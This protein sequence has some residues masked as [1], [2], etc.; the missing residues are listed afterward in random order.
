LSSLLGTGSGVGI[1]PTKKAGSM[2]AAEISA[3][4]LPGLQEEDIQISIPVGH[5]SDGENEVDQPHFGSVALDLQRRRKAAVFDVFAP[6][7]TST[8]LRNGRSAPPTLPISAASRFTT[9]Q[10]TRHPLSLS[11]LHNAVQGAVASKRYACSHLLALRF[12]E[13]DADEAYWENVRSVMGLLTSTFVDAS[14]RLTEALDDLDKTK[15]QDQIPTPLPRS[16]PSSD[17]GE[18]H[19]LHERLLSFAPMPSHLAR[20]AAHVDVISTALSDARDHLEECVAS[21]RNNSPHPEGLY[22]SGSLYPSTPASLPLQETPALRAYERLRRELGLALRECERG[23]ERLLD[24][25]APRRHHVPDEDGT[26]GEDLPGLGHDHGSDESDKPDETIS[27]VFG[28]SDDGNI[29][30]SVVGPD[31]GDDIDDATSHL[32]LATSSQHLPPPGI[33]QVFEAET[34]GEGSFV[35]EKSKLSR[36]ERIRLMK[37]RRESGGGL[38]LGLHEDL[39]PRKPAMEMWGPGGE[40]VQELK[41]VIWKVGERRRKMAE[42]QAQ[43]ATSLP[44]L[45]DTTATGDTT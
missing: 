23:R 34:D 19:H 30:V 39:L 43:T 2:S 20:F 42:N 13:D 27:P 14:S 18:S 40:V 1:S 44:M 31:T 22:P 36:E 9:M 38:G 8:S 28:S 21:I 16:S 5:E 45:P 26:D 7:P 4:P 32:L 15:F 24:I 29:G 6:A 3:L 17:G 25:V 35:R 10:T 37:A 33:E 12:N 11:A 41:D